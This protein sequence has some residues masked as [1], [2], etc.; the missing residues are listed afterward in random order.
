MIV[1]IIV[2]AKIIS[3]ENMLN[4]I[5]DEAKPLIEATR[6]EEGCIDYNLYNLAE[7][8]NT[9]LFVEKWD[10]EDSLKFHLKQAH[11]IEFG[12]A[13]EEY[14]ATDLDISVYSSEAVEL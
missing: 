2:L 11:F 13:I 7:G 9:L 6:A 4:K 1:L 10:S 5:V 12:S 3:K 14:L 8:D